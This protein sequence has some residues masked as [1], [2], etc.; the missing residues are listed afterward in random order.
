MNSILLTIDSISAN[1]AKAM[2]S[3]ASCIH[4][5]DTNL[6]DVRIVQTVCLTILII[7]L[8]VAIVIIIGQNKHLKQE[9]EL[10][11]TRFNNNETVKNNEFELY[12]KRQEYERNY[13]S[14]NQSSD[15][16]H[17]EALDM[18]KEI[19][20]LTKDKDGKADEDFAK[21]LYDLYVIIKKSK[22]K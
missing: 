4:T 20:Q 21:G 1:V 15:T 11:K 5:A 10:E 16:N 9:I 12:K 2:D 17:D 19:V 13:K 14:S 22:N 6:D 7:A 18:L 3:C 8:I